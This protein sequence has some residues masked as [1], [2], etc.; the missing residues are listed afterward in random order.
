MLTCKHIAW[1]TG[2]P[3]SRCACLAVTRYT[4][5]IRK[6]SQP[7]INLTVPNRILTAKTGSHRSH[8]LLGFTLV[9]LLVVIA[10]IGILVSLL[11]PAVQ[12]AR[13]AARRSQCMNN[14][15]QLGIALHNIHD[16]NKSLPP[17]TAPGETFAYMTITKG[18]YAKGIGYTFFNWLLPY[19][20]EGNIFQ[21]AESNVNTYVNGLRIKAYVISTYLCAS[22]SSSPGALINS[23][24][25]RV[26]V[27]GEPEPW[28]VGNYAANYLAFGDPRVPIVS[29]GIAAARAKRVEATRK[30]SHL[31]DGL[32]HSL[33]FGERY[34]TCGET[35]NPDTALANLWSDSNPAFRPLMCI[36]RINQTPDHPANQP[37]PCLVFQVQPDWVFNCQ[38]LRTQTPHTTMTA[39]FADGSV[40][41]L[42]GGIDELVWA[43]LCNATDGEAPP[44]P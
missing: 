29:P 23:L 41:S 26:I 6:A 42:D 25:G 2:P 35:G 12:S 31:T 11:L 33:A 8:L 38:S 16:T 24:N 21:A 17:L 43:R 27:N 5:N 9:E 36:N 39:G 22:D 15:K 19:L 7:G 30:F 3:G 37:E 14:M 20:E 18:P 13:E 28:T 1:Q 34:G 4:A 44:I 40:H 10:I 32:S